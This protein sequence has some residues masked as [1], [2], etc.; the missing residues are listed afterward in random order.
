MV[1]F[2]TNN[3][4]RFMQVNLRSADRKVYRSEHAL[5]ECFRQPLGLYV[6]QKISS[7]ILICSNVEMMYWGFLGI[8]SR[9]NYFPWQCGYLERYFLSTLMVF[10]TRYGI[11]GL[12]VS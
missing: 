5:S 9:S 8:G 11:F 10:G 2:T 4:A 6:S 1:G 12:A 7:M 3:F